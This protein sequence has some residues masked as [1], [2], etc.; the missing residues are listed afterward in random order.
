M[1]YI[2]T[3][4]QALDL[5]IW[6][7]VAATVRIRCQ[8]PTVNKGAP[9]MNVCPNCFPNGGSSGTPDHHCILRVMDS[10]CDNIA[11]LNADALWIPRC[12]RVVEAD[13]IQTPQAQARGQNGT[14]G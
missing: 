5:L 14:C 3:V 13:S 1:N 11:N 2:S 7:P 10:T 8:F 6:N 9:T 12:D 4:H